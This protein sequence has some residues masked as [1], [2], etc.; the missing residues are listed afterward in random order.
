MI[1]KI[2]VSAANFAIDKPYSYRIPQDLTVLPGMR[3][4]VP[5]G[6]GNK[7]SEGV[8]LGVEEGFAP[9]LKSVE[10][11]L[12]EKPLLGSNALRLAAFM[13][14]RYFCTFYDAVR[15]ML[16]AGLWFRTSDTFSLVPD[17]GWEEKTIKQADALA[18]LKLLKDLGGEA[19]E[20]IL[21]D[22]IGSE[23]RFS[24]AIAY[25]QKKKW[26]ENPRIK[27]NKSLF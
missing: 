27:P 9:D 10:Q 2:A 14:E 22:A 6:R 13:R 3:V 11:V 17:T 5:F 16:P 25:L 24:A 12:D 18:V 8:V 26:S 20:K 19:P 23:E 7:R 4:I 1:A 15:V 21:Y